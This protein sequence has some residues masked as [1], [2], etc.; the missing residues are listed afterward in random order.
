MTK[1]VKPLTIII[2]A[3]YISSKVYQYYKRKNDRK[4]KNNDI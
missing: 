2:I 1:A 4:T 3:V